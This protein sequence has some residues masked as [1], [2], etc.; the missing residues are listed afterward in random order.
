MATWTS[1]L[2][3]LADVSSHAH[4]NGNGNGKVNGSLSDLKA[5]VLAGGRGTRLAPYTSVLPKP[6]MPIGDQSILE[7]VVHL[8]DSDA[9]IG[10]ADCDRCRKIPGRRSDGPSAGERTPCEHA[11][12]CEPARLAHRDRIAGAAVPAGF[13][14]F[15]YPRCELC[16][17]QFQ[18][19]VS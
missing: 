1:D 11:D 15:E 17:A 4:V 5:I 14:R 10:D 6:L 2:D 9:I 19:P 7:V 16:L 13:F 18:R 3:L 8:A 12:G